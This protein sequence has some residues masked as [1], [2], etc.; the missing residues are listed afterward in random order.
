MLGDIDQLKDAVEC[1][2]VLRQELQI[3]SSAMLS[4]SQLKL[5]RNTLNKLGILALPNKLEKSF[6]IYNTTFEDKIS[7]NIKA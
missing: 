6:S 4:P 7:G 1:G 5:S 3:G 2:K